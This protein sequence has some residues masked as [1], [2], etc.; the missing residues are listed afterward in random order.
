MFVP[1][2]LSFSLIIFLGQIPELEL[3]GQYVDSLK[4]FA[5]VIS[6]VFLLEDYISANTL[7]LVEYFKVF[8]SD[9]KYLEGRNSGDS[10]LISTHLYICYSDW[11]RK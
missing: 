7:I 5:H 3:L 6:F 9:A 2:I 8:L 1:E 4:I 10:I 11:K